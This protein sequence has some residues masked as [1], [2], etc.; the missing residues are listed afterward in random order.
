MEILLEYGTSRRLLRPSGGIVTRCLLEEELENTGWR[1]CIDVHDTMSTQETDGGEAPTCT[2]YILQRWE[3]KWNCFIDVSNMEEVKDGDKLTV[4][5]KPGNESSEVK[6]GTEY[7]T[8]F[9]TLY[10]LLSVE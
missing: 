8:A 1:G 5:L 10:F 6:V 9:L 4:V 7:V 2:K 3:H